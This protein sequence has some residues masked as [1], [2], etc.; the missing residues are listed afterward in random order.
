MKVKTSSIAEG[1]INNMS[2]EERDIISRSILKLNNATRVLPLE[3]I[4]NLK[5]VKGRPDLL[6][7]KVNHRIRA[8]IEKNDKVLNL[9]DIIEVNDLSR[10]GYIKA[11][12]KLRYGVKSRNTVR[13]RVLGKTANVTKEVIAKAGKKR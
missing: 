4:P 1:L 11:T 12:R 13:P 10:I 9:I 6:V 3:R 8:I 7:Y 5:M 2:I